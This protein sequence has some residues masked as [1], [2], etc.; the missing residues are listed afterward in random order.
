MKTTSLER[1][2]NGAGILLIMA[3]VMTAGFAIGRGVG[4]WFVEGV[5]LR[6]ARFP[7]LLSR[8]VYQFY[9]IYTLISSNNPFSRL[10][11]Y[12]S[13]I[14]ANM[15]DDEFIRNR[16]QQEQVP[17]IKRTLLWILGFSKN[18]SATLKYYTSLYESGDPE[19][20]KDILELMERL[21]PTYYTDFLKKV[22]RPGAARHSR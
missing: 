12:Y 4:S 16:Y 8:P 10:S 3:A 14:D 2:K 1:I 17:V 9:D 18:K 6:Q 20:R 13:L 15:I 5:L 22:R 11:G 19:T 21:D 7:L